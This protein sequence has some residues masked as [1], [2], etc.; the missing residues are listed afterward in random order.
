MPAPTKR[1][2]RIVV[3]A[4]GEG[5]TFEHLAEE[6]SRQA[7]KGRRIE[8]A[9]VVSNNHN[10]GVLARA[11]ARGIPAVSIGHQ[12]LSNEE[13][14]RRVAAAVREYGP[15]LIVMAGYLRV[16]SREFIDGF[17]G[18]VIN[19]HPALLPKHG[20]PGMY[21]RHVHEAVLANHETES[22]ASVHW[23]IPR[24]DGG[25]TIS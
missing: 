4:S 5:T 3:L 17:D 22:G 21:G 25:A 23:A 18:R 15:D 11:A 2:F 14:S 6:F 12:G 9:A 19:V 20:G 16:L 10:A 24:V 1:P 7:P 8:I 13:H